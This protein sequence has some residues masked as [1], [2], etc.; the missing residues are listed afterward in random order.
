M[1]WKPIF[2]VSLFVAALHSQIV[3]QT[4]CP[5]YFQYFY[6]DGTAKGDLKIPPPQNYAV[7]LIQL[8]MLVNTRLTTVRINFISPRNF[9]LKVAFWF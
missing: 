9:D 8:H 4:P 1:T 2:V 5:Q 7:I 3:P 6:E